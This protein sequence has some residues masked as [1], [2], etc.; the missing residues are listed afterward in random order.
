M[1]IFQ[2]YS[3]GDQTFKKMAQTLNRE[4]FV[5]R[6]SQPSFGRTSLSYILNNRF[7]I[8]EIDWKGTRHPGKHMP[9]VDRDTFMTCQDILKGR[10]RRTGASDTYLA[11]G[12]FRCRICGF[13][14]TGERIRR[15]LKGGGVRE[16][17]YYR[18][19][20]FLRIAS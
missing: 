12:L 2:L 18:C 13:A 5:Y 4:G 10:N 6:P 17:I 11:G 20:T 1:R 14:I 3:L 9:L 15:K 7:Y 16:H 8:G 19:G